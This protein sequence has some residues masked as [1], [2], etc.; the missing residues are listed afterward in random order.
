MLKKLEHK[1]HLEQG[2]QILKLV[3]IVVVISALC[4]GSFSAAQQTNSLNS[5]GFANLPGD[6]IEIQL[7]FDSTP[8]DP[9]GFVLDNP[10]RISLDLV[11]VSS[12]LA[13]Q[14]FNIDSNNAKSVVVLDDGS[15]TRLVVNLDQLVN[16][17]SRVTGNTLTIRVGND[18][19]AVGG[20]SNVGQTFAGIVSAGA[21][22]ITDVTFQRGDDEEGQVVI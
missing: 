21:N 17:E 8:P 12:A 3:Q 22:E 15:R 10:A 13:Q 11:G 19:V 18:N 16:Y 9:S 7:S 2:S 5:I 4:I 20:V 1:L 14:R 6:S